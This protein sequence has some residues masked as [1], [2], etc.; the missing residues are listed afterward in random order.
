MAAGVTDKLW[1]VADMVRVVEE[2]EAAPPI[3]IEAPSD[4]IAC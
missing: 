3:E 2:Y 1:D 4:L